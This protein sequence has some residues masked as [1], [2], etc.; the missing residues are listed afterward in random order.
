MKRLLEAF[1]RL[2]VNTTS[3]SGNSYVPPGGMVPDAFA[4]YGL[5]GGVNNLNE[6]IDMDLVAL[7]GGTS[8]AIALTA[9]QYTNNIIDYSGSPAGGVAIT[10]P[11]AAQIIAQLP[12]SMYANG[13][14]NLWQKFINDSS[15]QTVTITANTGVTLNG[16]MTIATATWR[17]FLIN[18][19]FA[20]GLVNVIN[21]GGGSL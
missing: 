19:N 9:A 11:T 4:L 15:G 14:V 10:A 8:V 16:T 5:I 17:D 12:Q 2:C 3:F 20:T 1:F 7:I 6:S 13:S 18:V 21:L